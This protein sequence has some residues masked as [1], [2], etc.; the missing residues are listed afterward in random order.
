MIERF[1]RNEKVYYSFD[2]GDD[3]TRNNYLLDFLNSIT[4]NGLPP[5]KLKVKKDCPVILL[6][7]LDPH[8]G[9][10]NGTRLVIRGFQNN[11]IDAEIVNGHTRIP[12][13][14]FEDHLLPFKF[15]RKQFS[16]K[17]SFT[18]TINKA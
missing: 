1:P 5:H 15:K 14:P 9:L 10:C 17:L 12:M 18:M 16:R 11:T 8:N 6:R 7:N 13:S 3:D 4:S 2:S